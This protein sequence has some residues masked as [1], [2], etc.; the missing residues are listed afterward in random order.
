MRRGG[1]EQPPALVE[2]AEQLADKG[3]MYGSAIWRRILE[4]I[5]ELTRDRRE[6]ESI[7]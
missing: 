6:G 4:A 3:D 5:E 1:R 2:R 7:N